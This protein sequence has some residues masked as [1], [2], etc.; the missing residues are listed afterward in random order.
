MC[1]RISQWCFEADD[2]DQLPFAQ[3]MLDALLA[4]NIKHAQLCNQED[5][6]IWGPASVKKQAVA[7]VRSGFQKRLRE[8]PRLSNLHNI[9]PPGTER[10]G[11]VLLPQV[12]Q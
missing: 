5:D 11:N 9:L 6:A 12:R 4:V 7:Q 8:D 3:A 2:A 10:N 1:L